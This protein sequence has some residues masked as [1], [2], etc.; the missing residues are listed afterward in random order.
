MSGIAAAIAFDGSDPGPALAS[1]CAAGAHRAPDGVTMWT[2]AGAALARLHRI[3]LDEQRL[4]GQPAVEPGGPH[5]AVF[6][7]R[8][9]NRA[10]LA[11]LLPDAGLRAGD[12][13]AVYALAAAIRFGEGC[14]ARLAG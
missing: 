8:L 6:D 5:V 11:A 10:E 13:D 4:D 2:R 1:L 3:T 7:G 9:D 12:D 14:A